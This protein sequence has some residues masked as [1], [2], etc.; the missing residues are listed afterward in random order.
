MEDSPHCLLHCELAD[1]QALAIGRLM[2]STWPKPGKDAAIRAASLIKLGADAHGPEALASR[3]FVVLDGTKVI[4]HAA[5]QPRELQT[6]AGPLWVMG[7]GAVCTD[8]AY[9]GQGLGTTIVKAA[10]EMID[11]GVAQ[12]SLFQTS[13]EVRPFYEKLGSCLVENRIVDSTADDPAANPFWDDVVMRYPAEADWP[14]GEID[15]R[16]PGY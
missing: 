12:H 5:M 6:T 15:L 1:E 11:A 14:E 3:S 4:A 10:F 16:G 2:A 8:G 9:R 7:L 13:H